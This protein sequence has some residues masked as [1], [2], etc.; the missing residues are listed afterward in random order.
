MNP[1][2]IYSTRNDVTETQTAILCL[3]LYLYPSGVQTP[4][5]AS[6]KVSNFH[7]P[8]NL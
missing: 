5:Q 3:M 7:F 8:I 6:R 1:I 2:H 4:S